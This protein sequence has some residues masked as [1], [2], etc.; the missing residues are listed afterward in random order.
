[1]T[2]IEGLPTFSP[3]RRGTR[4]RISDTQATLSELFY[5]T[6]L[7]TIEWMGIS[8][9]KFFHDIHTGREPIISD[10]FYMHMYTKHV[11]SLIVI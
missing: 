7:P 9:T 1:M 11:G 10:I 2:K 8:D 3:V 4:K 5:P 6:D